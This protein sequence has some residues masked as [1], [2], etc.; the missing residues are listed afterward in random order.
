MG[1]VTQDRLRIPLTVL[2]SVS[3]VRRALGC[4]R[5]AAYEHLRRA[6]VTVAVAPGSTIATLSGAT[7]R[8]SSA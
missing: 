7:L 2:V 6:I 8:T 1:W 5:S 4:S 3:D